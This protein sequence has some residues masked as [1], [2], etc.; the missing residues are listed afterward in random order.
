MKC[1]WC[2]LN[3]GNGTPVFIVKRDAGDYIHIQPICQECFDQMGGRDIF[4]VLKKVGDEFPRI[5][6]RTIWPEGK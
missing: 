2:S 3:N 6:Y 1:F 4:Q 5:K